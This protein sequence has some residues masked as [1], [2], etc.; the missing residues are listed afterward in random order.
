[1]NSYFHSTKRGH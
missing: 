1:M